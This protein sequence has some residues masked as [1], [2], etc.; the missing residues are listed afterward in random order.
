MY[1][2]AYK[3]R[4]FNEHTIN[5]L[6]E[7]Q[8]W[9]SSPDRF[10]DPFDTAI[11]FD[12]SRF[13]M[14]DLPPEQFIEQVKEMEATV[15]S[16]GIWNPPKIENPI[17]TEEWYEK[18]LAT[19]LSDL[20]PAF[21]SEVK[22]TLDECMRAVHEVGIQRMNNGLRQ[23]FGV[24][25]LSANPTSVL[26]WSH[27]SDSHRGFCVEYDFDSLEY[28][29]LR[30]RLCFPVFYRRKR[31]DATRYLR[32]RTM[33]DFNNLFGQYLCLLKSD[34]WSYE[35]EWRIVHA[36]GPDHANGLFDMPPPSALILGARSKDD[37]EAWARDFCAR[38][39]IPLRR[40]RQSYDTLQLSLV[41]V[42][43]A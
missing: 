13:H 12:A 22:A 14:D 3:Y 38:R 40:A 15:K 27:Y 20:E 42:A 10:N 16:G 29:N 18:L 35:Q 31:T 23:G 19:H 37:D 36:I 34:E 33:D 9:F 24:L 28:S 5:A 43:A 2:L 1:Q 7:D 21:R 11:Y 30:K 8:L 26:M 6:E 4:N 17:T 32:R 41:D 39:G 25:S